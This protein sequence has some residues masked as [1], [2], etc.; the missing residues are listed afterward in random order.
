MIF[1]TISSP[2][3]VSMA[4]QF[5]SANSDIVGFFRAGNKEMTF[6]KFFFSTF[7]FKPTLL[8]A[9]RAPFKSKA[10]S[11]IFFFFQEFLKDFLFAINLV[12]DSKIVSMTLSLLARKEDPV[13]VKSTIASTSSGTFTSVAPH[14][15]YTSALTLFFLK[16]SL[17][18]LTS[19][20]AILLPSKSLIE[21]I[22]ESFGTATTNLTLPKP[23]FE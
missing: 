14:E 20:V 5:L 6:C 7:I 18:T 17:V 22:F 13:S 10:T 2:I 9:L 15:N 23:V 3:I 1:L 4:N 12:V 19:S 11:L 21:F 16:K 8:S